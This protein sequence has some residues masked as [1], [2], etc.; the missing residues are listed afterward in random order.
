MDEIAAPKP[1][2]ND[3]F[4]ECQKAVEDRVQQL[5]ADAHVSGWEHGETLAAIIEVAENLALGLG[6]NDALEKLLRRIKR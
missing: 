1:G 2:Q 4:V 3:R 5:V 6:E